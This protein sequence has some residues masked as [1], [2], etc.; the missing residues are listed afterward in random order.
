M[1]GW[2]SFTTFTAAL[3]TFLM[4]CGHDER[5]EVFLNYRLQH[6]R[7]NNQHIRHSYTTS[8]ALLTAAVL[9]SGSVHAQIPENAV[10]V[11]G[12]AIDFGCTP[13][14]VIAHEYP[15]GS[16]ERQMHGGVPKAD[17]YHHVMIALF[18]RNTGMRITDAKVFAR[19]A[20][21]TEPSVPEQDAP[22]EAMTIAGALTYGH[23]F[24]MPD[25]GRYQV[26]LAITI[27]KQP[28]I[29][30]TFVCVSA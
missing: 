6:T 29:T 21:P 16:A 17:H 5:T 11:A 26:T 28:T 23:Y 19:V 12:I 7:R 2:Q 20:I 15:V 10:V 13:A 3:C 8:A 24:E 14:A 9:G 1:S 22:L 4:Y 25:R 30:T 27:P 18:D